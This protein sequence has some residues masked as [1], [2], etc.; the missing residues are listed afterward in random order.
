MQWVNC[1]SCGSSE[2]RFLFRAPADPVEKLGYFSVSKCPKCEFVFTNPQA[3][4]EDLKKLYSNEYY[5]EEHQRFW[6][7]IERVINS[8]RQSR[9]EKIEM[10]KKNGRI[11]DIGCGRGKM[12]AGLKSRG[13]ETYGTELSEESSR[14][15][16]ESLGLNVY[17]GDFLSSNF[18]AD[19]FDCITLFHVLEHLK[20]PLKNLLEIRR[21]LKEDGLLLIA[22]PNFGGGQSRLSGRAWFHLDVPRHYS[23]FTFKILKNFLDK[24]GFQVKKVNHFSL[25]YDP[26]GF[27]QSLYNLAGIEHNLLYRIFRS[28]KDRLKIL[29]QHRLQALFILWTLPVLGSPSLILS[30]YDSMLR[31]GGSLELYCWKR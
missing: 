6:P 16:R 21:V 1:P 17:P 13:W 22:L 18:P 2:L 20:D 23:H 7:V 24:S 29:K 25:E 9:I 26:F 10:F 5:G 12:L 4:E 31:G 3:D 19:F 11:L 28:K 30:L 8:F 14:Y 27:L 15:A